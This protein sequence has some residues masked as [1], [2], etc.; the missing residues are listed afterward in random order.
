MRVVSFSCLGFYTELALSFN[1]GP[2]L[3]SRADI[4]QMPT[5][6]SSAHCDLMFPM[7][8]FSH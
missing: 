3:F 8:R 6:Q 1:F 4:S 5:L 7:D 2:F